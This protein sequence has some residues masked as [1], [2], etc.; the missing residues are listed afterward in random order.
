MNFY[1]DQAA[2]R[3]DKFNAYLKDKDLSEGS[4]VLRYDARTEHR[5]DAKFL[6]RWE[7]PFIV[8]H[9]YKNGS[10][11]LQDL[12]GKLHQTRVNGWRLKPYLVRIEAAPPL[13]VVEEEDE[14]TS[15]QSN[16]LPD[17]EDLIFPP[18]D[19]FQQDALEA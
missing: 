10:Y 6:P 11:Q 4:L 3:R 18:S 15:I 7:G 8:Y 17:E 12:S 2:R 5:H 9:R 14:A 19:F 16:D 13:C 1:L